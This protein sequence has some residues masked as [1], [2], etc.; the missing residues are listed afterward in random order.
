MVVAKG[1]AAIPIV[2]VSVFWLGIGGVIPWFIKGPNRRFIEV[3]FSNTKPWNVVFHLC[4]FYYILTG[5]VSI[6]H[7]RLN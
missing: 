4:L 5:Y 2:I 3:L 6:F 1:E 7:D